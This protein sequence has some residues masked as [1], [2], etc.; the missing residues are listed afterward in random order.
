MLS[1]PHISEEQLL[2]DPL[3]VLTVSNQ[4]SNGVFSNASPGLTVRFCFFFFFFFF[5]GLFCHWRFLEEG[6]NTYLIAPMLPLKFLF[7]LSGHL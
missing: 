3:Y 2:Y 5:G 6:V 1:V 4:R 7:F